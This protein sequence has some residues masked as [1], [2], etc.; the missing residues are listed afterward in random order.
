MPGEA[1][2]N[3]DA[4]IHPLGNSPVEPSAGVEV[5][6]GLA[7]TAANTAR[8]AIS[9]VASASGAAGAT[10][11]LAKT[12]AVVN[13][14]QQGAS[15]VQSAV[16][17]VQSPSVEAL[18]GSAGQIASTV[19][20]TAGASQAIRTGLAVA[21][22]AAQYANSVVGAARSMRGAESSTDSS[23]S[24]RGGG[25]DGGS[26]RDGRDT[27]DRSRARGAQ[28]P[29]ET[30]GFE[31][32]DDA[33]PG[34]SFVSFEGREG[35]SLLYEFHLVLEHEHELQDPEDLLGKNIALRLERDGHDR[36]FAG[37]VRQT[38]DVG[39]QGQHQRAR[40]VIVPALA[41]LG[42]RKTSRIFQGKTVPEIV[43]EVL[44]DGLAASQ[45]S[46]DAR[47]RGTYLPREYCVQYNETD[48]AFV[49][50]LL[51]EE[52]IGFFFEHVATKEVLVLF[53]DNGQLTPMLEGDADKVSVANGNP[54]MHPEHTVHSFPYRR[55]LTST[56]STVR[57]WD[58]TYPVRKESNVAASEGADTYEVYSGGGEITLANYDN[59]RYAAENSRKQAQLRRQLQVLGQQG[60]EGRGNVTT[61]VPGRTFRLQDHAQHALEQRYALVSIEHRGAN[62]RISESGRSDAQHGY[63]NTFHAVP[64]ATPWRPPRRSRPRLVGVQTALVVRGSADENEEIFTDEHG[65]IKVR[66]HWDRVEEDDEHASCWMRVAQSWAGADW[67][68]VFIPRVGMEVLVQFVD[69]NPDRPLITG[70]VY[71]GQNK[72]PYPLPTKK[73]Q[74]TIKTRSTPGGDG[75][76]ELRFEDAAGEEEVFLRAQKD[77]NEMVRNNHSTRV[78]A[79]QTNAVRSNQNET[80]GGNQSMSVT[81]NRTKSITGDETTT[82]QKNRTETVTLDETITV[83]GKRTET[84]DQ[85]ESV[86]IT[87]GR[88]VAVSGAFEGFTDRTVVTGNRKAVVTAKEELWAGEK[89]DHVGTTFS[90]HAGKYELH[91]GGTTLTLDANHV[92]LNAADWVEVKHGAGSVKIESSG[93]VAVKAPNELVLECGASRIELKSDGTITIAGSTK[94][95]VKAGSSGVTCEPAKVSTHAPQIAS[96]ASGVHEISGSIV[97]VN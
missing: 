83:H 55:A 36:R 87:G 8:G 38:E 61:F 79:N 28:L 20:Q 75:Y 37:I 69:G 42:L 48:L 11:V 92:E 45:R 19:A 86:T 4:P 32:Q 31:V 21:Q 41:M 62:H 18:A 74:S 73:T 27:S 40:I 33:A 88:K 44:R 82:V 91:Q 51:A 66:F 95:D 35:L 67:G 2:S 43:G 93:K 46:F 68:F 10:E 29:P 53:D 70:T 14:I 50:R 60:S 5:A 39:S 58:W 1:M 6:Q 80:V 54:Q 15:L 25:S 7:S 47:L 59:P 77:F 9:N 72:P 64:H 63:S 52:G 57:D 81:G 22:Q 30:Y 65:R 94:V 16:A 85:R 17:A 34:W 96:Q 49:E 71:N 13:A 78:G 23:S 76:N 97:K 26:A 3:E 12:E 84:V 90:V 89:D 56:K 24:T